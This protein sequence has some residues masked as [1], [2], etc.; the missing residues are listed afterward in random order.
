[1]AKRPVGITV[2]SIFTAVVGTATLVVG[3]AG[4]SPLSVVLGF[5]QLIASYGLWAIQPWGG[6]LA[7]AVYGFDGLRKGSEA[8]AGEP[9]AAGGLVVNAAIVGYLYV[10]RELFGD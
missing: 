9:I 7:G 2:L 10:N 3:V 1:M 4:G 6:V 8:L 5:G